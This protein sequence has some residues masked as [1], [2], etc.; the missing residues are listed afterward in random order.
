MLNNVFSVKRFLLAVVVGFSFLASAGQAFAGTDL[1]ATCPSTGSCSISPAATPLFDESGWAPGSTV[2]QQLTVT[3]SSSQ[4]GYVA[5][6]ATNYLETNDLGEVVDLEIR[7]GSVAGTVI[8]SGVTMQD[9]RDDGYFTIDA[10]SASQT[11]D[12]FFI[13]TMQSTAGNEYQGSSLGFDLKVGLELDA[14]PPTS[15]GG[16]GSGDSGG[17]SGGS[18]GG[19]ASAPVCS[20]QAPVSAPTLLI[21]NV[22]TNTVSLSWTP[23]SPVTHYAISFTRTSDGEQYGSPNIGNVTSFTVQ[24]LSGGA[25]YTFEVFGV[26]GCAPGPRSNQAGTGVVPGPFIEGRPTGGGQVLGETDEASPSPS[27]SPSPTIEG[28]VE[29]VSSVCEQWRF[30]VPWILLVMQLLFVLASEYFFRKDRGLTKH[31]IAVGITLVSIFLF[32]LLRACDCYQG[33]SFSILLFLCEWYW[34]VAL[35]LT[36]IEKGFSYAFIEEVEEKQDSQDSK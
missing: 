8:Y 12:Y 25:N 20:D 28:S 5:V 4:N 19:S 26:N 17:G 1:T 35:V 31:F 33:G 11:K 36:A 21:T 29:G 23:V 13:A 15:G 24:Q 16:S 30:Y 27:P 6:E 34:V 32:Y 22:G 7:E 2:T 3:N 9:F 18:G 10:I 14:I